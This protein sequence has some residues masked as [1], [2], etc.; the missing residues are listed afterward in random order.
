MLLFWLVGSVSPRLLGPRG[1]KR[2][3]HLPPERFDP[4]TRFIGTFPGIVARPHV[5]TECSNLGRQLAGPDRV[6]FSR[7]MSRVLDRVIDERAIPS[8]RV[9]D[10]DAHLLERFGLTNTLILL[11]AEGLTIV[12][13]DTPLAAELAARSVRVLD[14][15]A[16][17]KLAPAR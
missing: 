16:A 14:L 8:R 3:R 12:T 5:L 2:V 6:A 10:A 1:F 7:L 11:S 17:A 4:L 9:C 13:E 15:A